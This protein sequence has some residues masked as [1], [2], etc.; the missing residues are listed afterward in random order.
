MKISAQLSNI[1]MSIQQCYEHFFTESSRTS[2]ND[3]KIYSNLT[4]LGY[5]CRRP[6]ED[7]KFKSSECSS[8]RVV[9]ES[10]LGPIISRNDHGKLTETEIYDRLSSYMPKSVDS[11]FLSELK[12]RM[13]SK[14]EFK[15]LYDVYLPN[16]S[17][18]KSIKSRPEHKLYTQSSDA[19]RLKVP[20]LTDL[21]NLANEDSEPSSHIVAFINQS[22]GCDV[23]YYRF[24]LGQTSIP[25]S[26]LQ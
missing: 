10:T 19:T 26:K 4:K 20:K 6:T 8:N 12:S 2:L 9:A 11:S 5:I 22:G 17:F 15:H 24:N 23:S 21:I 7:R 14:S 1:P 18:K 25:L 3:Y 13:V 16:K